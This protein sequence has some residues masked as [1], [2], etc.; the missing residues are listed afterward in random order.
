VKNLHK[1]YAYGEHHEREACSCGGGHHGHGRFQR[2]FLTKE[3][4]I[5]KL[6]NYANELKN[7]LVAVQDHIKE[8]K[9]KTK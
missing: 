6:E 7:E 8:L 9:S 4:K 5:E 2:R 1:N 3:E